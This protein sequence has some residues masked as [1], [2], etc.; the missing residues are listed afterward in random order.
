[1]RLGLRVTV[2]EMS[3]RAIERGVPR[4]MHINRKKISIA[5]ELLWQNPNLSEMRLPTTFQRGK[6]GEGQVSFQ[7]ARDLVDHLKRCERSNCPLPMG[8]LRSAMALRL[9]NDGMAPE[10]RNNWKQ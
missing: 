9:F 4:C 2:G 1:M 5:V 7:Q 3:T 10:M 8:E 6:Y